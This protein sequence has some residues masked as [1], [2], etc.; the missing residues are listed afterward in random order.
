VNS[1]TPEKRIKDAIGN[2]AIA[3]SIIALANKEGA[4]L[5]DIAT[6]LE[7]AVDTNQITQWLQDRTNLHG[8]ATLLD[9]GIESSVITQLINNQADLRDITTNT[10]LLLNTGLRV[11]LINE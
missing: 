6:L 8:V 5:P 1:K 4:N 3:Q 7:N 11:S 9:Q 2:V 10:Q